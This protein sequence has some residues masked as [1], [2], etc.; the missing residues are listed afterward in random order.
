M[1]FLAREIEPFIIAVGEVLVYETPKGLEIISRDGGGVNNGHVTSAPAHLRPR[2]R[3]IPTIMAPP[4]RLTRQADDFGPARGG[5][6]GPT[7]LGW[8]EWRW[9]AAVDADIVSLGILEWGPVVA[10]GRRGDAKGRNICASAYYRTTGTKLVR[11][12]ALAIEH[13][14]AV[15]SASRRY[16]QGVHSYRVHVLACSRL[17]GA[18]RGIRIS[19]PVKQWSS[20]QLVVIIHDFERGLIVAAGVVRQASRI[21]PPIG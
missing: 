15:T 18:E 7:G 21:P 13:A 3:L 16:E 14:A 10:G 9:N 12:G 1:V 8:R 4:R 2:C 6:G 17:E 11:R 20:G 19:L 5:G